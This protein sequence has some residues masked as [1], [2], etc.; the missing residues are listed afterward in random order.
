MK[1]KRKLKFE[2]NWFWMFS[3]IY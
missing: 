1:F 2:H 3:R